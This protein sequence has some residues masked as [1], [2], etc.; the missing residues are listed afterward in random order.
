MMQ[1]STDSGIEELHGEKRLSI[2]SIEDE[3][4]EEVIHLEQSQPARHTPSRNSRSLYAKRMS[5]PAV[6]NPSTRLKYTL[7]LNVRE[8]FKGYGVCDDTKELK[9][10]RRPAR[11]SS[12]FKFRDLGSEIHH[13]SAHRIAWAEEEKEEEKKIGSKKGTKS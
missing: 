8:A 6:C 9:K 10:P 5:C 4:F 7:P 12:S 3:N 1:E 11:S 2:V 13:H